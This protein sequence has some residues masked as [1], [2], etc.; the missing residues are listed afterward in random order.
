[1][2]AFRC[3]FLTEASIMA[4][5]TDPNV[6]RLEGVVTQSH[7]LMI[8]TEFMENGSLDSYL[9]VQGPKLKMTQLVRMLR[10]VA[11]G[12]R[13]LSE[14]NYIHRDL[15]ARN[16]LV[17]RDLV[18]K[19]ADFGLSREIDV[20]AY[21]YTTKGGKI[22]IRWTAPE[23]CNFRKYSCASDVWSFG[24]VCWEV[25]SFGERPYWSWENKDVVRAL[26]ECYRLP[27]PPNC[28][29]CVYKLMLRCW[30]DERNQRPKFA[31]I[32]ELLDEMLANSASSDE[33]RRPSRVR[34]ALD[35]NPRAPTKVQLTSTR[36]FLARLGLDHYRPQFECAGFGN[37]SKLFHLDA[38]DLAILIGNI[39]LFLTHIRTNFVESFLRE[40]NYMRLV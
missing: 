36:T 9:R 35:I 10:D 13:Y 12:M 17:N 28:S 25:L 37:L 26:Q 24:V 16:I 2:F 8:V 22:P 29:D 3:D 4:Q 6:I 14:M 18:C 15:A 39:Q 5:F 1:L 23:A 31:E 20:D 32:V 19:V 11:S 38:N 7:P 30:L 33:L 27:P 40:F 34:E 21:E